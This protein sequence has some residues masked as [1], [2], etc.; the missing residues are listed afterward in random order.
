M[1]IPDD[2]PI[3]TTIIIII[4]YSHGV[5][6]S[7]LGTAA[8]FG[9]MHQPRMTDDGDCGAICGMKTGRGNGSTREK[10]AP[11]PLYPPQIPHD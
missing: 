9:V 11:A 3:F 1:R 2:R 8:M 4:F 5:R 10:L 7:P 6:L